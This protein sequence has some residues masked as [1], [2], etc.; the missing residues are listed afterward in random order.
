MRISAANQKQNISMA[1]AVP[2]PQREGQSAEKR[3]IFGNLPEAE[4]SISKEGLAA[5]R[6]TERTGC[7]GIMTGRDD[8]SKLPKAKSNEVYFE[9]LMELGDVMTEIS[10]KY[11]AEGE[12]NKQ[13]L[14]MDEVSAALDP[15]SENAINQS[16]LEFCRDKMLIFIS[17]RLSLMKEMDYIYYFEEGEI[18]EQG[19]HEALLQEDGKYAYMYRLQAEAYRTE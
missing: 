19:T 18:R 14:I 9:H 11:K 13:V 8:A 15:Y 10:K 3:Y 2:S 17:H 4:I 1:W 12:K 16:V 6:E 7:I 5:W